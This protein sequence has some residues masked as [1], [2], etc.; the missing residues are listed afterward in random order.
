MVT[1]ETEFIKSMFTR[2]GRN[3]KCQII[4]DSNLTDQEA[5]LL[6]KRFVNGLSIKECSEFFGLEENTICKKQC[7][8]AKKLYEFLNQ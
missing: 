6:T 1:K 4:V 7:K 5:E 2:L 8:A 3:S